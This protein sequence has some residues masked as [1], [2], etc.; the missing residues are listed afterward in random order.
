MRQQPRVGDAEAD[1]R[2][3]RLVAVAPHPVQYHAP[4]FRALASRPEFDFEVAFLE[5]L[6]AQL[7]GVG[8]GVPFEWDVPVLEGYRWR[9]L[10]TLRYR[11]S[12]WTRALKPRA[13]L[14]ALR[15][16]VLFLTGWQ[17]LPFIQ[18]L[19]AARQAGVPVL[20]RG[21]SHALKPRPALVRRM[22]GW[23]FRQIDGFLVI[24]QANRALYERHRIPAD[25]FFEAPYFVDNERFANE[26]A[27]AR[28]DRS[29]LR[30]SLGIPEAASCFIF[31]GKF[32]GLKCPQHMIRALG[33]VRRRRPD[34][35]V[36]GLFVGDGPLA[37]DLR[38]LASREGVSVT[39]TG[40]ANQTEIPRLYA[41]ADALVLPSEHENWGL[42]VN[43]AMACGL[44]ALVSDHVGC[45]DD[46]IIDGVTGA[47]YPFANIEAMGAVLERW[48][49]DPDTM[50]RLG[51]SAQQLVHSRYTVGRSVEA[52][53]RAAVAVCA[54]SPARA[55]S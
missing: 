6:D 5:L 38:A 52:V 47:S 27:V 41:A 25:R 44:P 16:D 45:R 32:L 17:T 31:S 8:F 26:A 39:F 24:G 46:L 54:R 48:A 21:D 30:R 55:T 11:R 43:E 7:Q 28:G 36:H 3:I 14:R 35:V 15:P 33:R 53:I 51:K 4:L 37:A 10:P 2:R 1:A 22:H 18:L 12:R 40:F 9:V 42:V 29:D 34:L 50:H 19:S 49:E 23:L 13:C 20:M